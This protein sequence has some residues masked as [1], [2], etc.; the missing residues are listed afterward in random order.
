[1]A[2]TDYEKV[3]STVQLGKIARAARKKQGLT[4]LDVAGLAGKSN[5]FLIDLERGKETLQIQM[6]IDVLTLLGL[7]L[8]IREKS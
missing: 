1:M 5:R 6:V 4:Q 7:E 8:I 2:I 3:T